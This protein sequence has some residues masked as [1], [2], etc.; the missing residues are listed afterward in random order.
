MIRVIDT[1]IPPVVLGHR[2]TPTL[3]ASSSSCVTGDEETPEVSFH[4]GLPVPKRKERRKEKREIGKEIFGG[5]K[6]LVS[7]IP[8][9]V[10]TH[11]NKAAFRVCLYFL[12]YSKP[13]SELGT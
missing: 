5:G 6:Q 4:E 7:I 13:Y 1:A 11:H 3:P 9:S 12:Q 10:G 8:T 2:Q